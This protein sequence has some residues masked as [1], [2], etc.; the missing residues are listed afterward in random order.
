VFL[1]ACLKPAGAHAQ[2]TEIAQIIQAA[3]KKVI[4]AADL[5]VE[6][7]QTETIE[8][9]DAERSLENSMDLS[10]LNGITSWVQDQKSLFAEYYQELW[11]IKNALATYEQVKAMIEKQEQIVAGYKQVHSIVGQDKHF[12]SAEVSQMYAVLTGIVNQST[13]NITRLTT[14]ITALLTQMNDAGR[15]RIIDE[16][17]RDIDKNYRDL[18]QFSQQT[19]LL[20]L[21]RAKDENDVETTE[22][23][24]GIE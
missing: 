2:I 3:I 19:Y 1:L 24:Y 10:E 20:S 14:V 18:S 11:D 7:L 16:T 6:N 22:A 15:L 13:Q 21:Q 5:V 4:V 23:M 8:L 12:T 17:G 9:Q